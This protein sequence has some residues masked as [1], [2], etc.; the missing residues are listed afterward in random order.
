M[1]LVKILTGLDQLVVDD[2]QIPDRGIQVFVAQGLLDQLQ[3]PAV[4]SPHVGKLAA[5]HVRR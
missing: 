2:I 3:P 4:F 5:E 1:L